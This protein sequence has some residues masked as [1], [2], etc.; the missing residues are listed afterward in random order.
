MNKNITII[1]IINHRYLNYLIG[2]NL[3]ILRTLLHLYTC[4]LKTSLVINTVEDSAR[5][6][7]MTHV[8]TFAKYSPKAGPIIHLGT[9][10]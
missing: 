10:S 6:D 4:D 2:I 3:K 1:L 9:T 7:V 8:H 5:H